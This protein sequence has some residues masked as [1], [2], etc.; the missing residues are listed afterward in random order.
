[1]TGLIA[2]PGFFGVFAED[3]GRILGSNFLDERSMICGL[4]PITVDADSQDVG[5]DWS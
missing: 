1:M 5:S 2:H 4:G 3:D